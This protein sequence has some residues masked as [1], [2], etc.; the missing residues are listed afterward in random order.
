MVCHGFLDVEARLLSLCTPCEI[1]GGQSAIG[2]GFCL[3]T[4]VSSHQC[5]KLMSPRRGT[6]GSLVSAVSRDSVSLQSYSQDTH[7]LSVYVTRQVADHWRSLQRKDQG[8]VLPSQDCH[9]PQVIEQCAAIVEWCSA[10]ENGR[11][12]DKSVLWCRFIHHGSPI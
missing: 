10:G 8:D 9:V 6:V 4:S 12:S 5:L 11:K 1:C 3:S 2:V 7:F